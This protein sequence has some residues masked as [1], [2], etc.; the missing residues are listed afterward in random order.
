MLPISPGDI[1]AWYRLMDRDAPAMYAMVLMVEPS[2]E[3]E[4]N[5]SGEQVFM[6]HVVRERE[7]VFDIKTKVGEIVPTKPMRS[8]LASSSPERDKSH[9]ATVSEPPTSEVYCVRDP[10]EC[11]A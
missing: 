1:A 11:H 2:R 7:R 6:A 10:R 3:G 5:E 8:T 4:V 9:G